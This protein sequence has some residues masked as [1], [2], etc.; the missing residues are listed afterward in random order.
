MGIEIALDDFGTGYSS[1]S[2]I[3]RFPLDKIKIDQA[4]V[5][6]LPLDVEST[7]I[8]K[9]VVSMAE[10]LGLKTIAEGVEAAEQVQFLKLLGCYEGQGYLFGRP[11]PA[12][13]LLRSAWMAGA[14][15]GEAAAPS[16][17]TGAMA[18]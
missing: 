11:Q 1:L 16:R 15:A 4:F 5:K 3:R 12:A 17:A 13:A 14:I 18:S 7:A 2:Y 9:A 10:S 6:G 8:I